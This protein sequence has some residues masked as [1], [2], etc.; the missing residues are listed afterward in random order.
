MEEIIK[1]RDNS[2]HVITGTGASQMIRILCEV[3]T[4]GD[5]ETAAISNAGP[6][7]TVLIIASIEVMHFSTDI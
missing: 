2:E 5:P 7:V 1:C 3:I 4:G 6:S